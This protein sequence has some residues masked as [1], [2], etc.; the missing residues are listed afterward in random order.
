MVSFEVAAEAYDRFMGRYSNRLAGPF[1]D[2]AGIK[3]GWRVLDV[4]CGPGALLGELVS[5]VGA[6]RVTGVD[7]A[8]G[9]VAAALDR[10]PGTLVRRAAAEDLPFEDDLFD[11]V[12]AQLAVHFM[13]DPVAGLAEMARVT[14]T[15]GV[16]AACVWDY[17]EG[18]GPLSTFWAVAMELDPGAPGETALPGTAR[19]DL[20]ALF[21]SAGIRDVEETTL[22]IGLQHQSFRDWWEP[23]E[24]GVGPA[25]AYVAGLSVSKRENLATRCREVLGNGPF[26][27][28]ATAWAATGLA[29]R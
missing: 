7:P 1:A 16:V 8:E 28:D 9:F 13:S 22:K 15:G 24:L 5:R 21:R 25:G 26:T 29:G 11:A 23:F 10:H 20:G 2:L 27:V 17:H 12:L 19:G 18:G 6:D 4:G 14:V 3:A